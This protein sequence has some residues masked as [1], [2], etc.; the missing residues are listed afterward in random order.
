[1]I[2]KNYIEHRVTMLI[3]DRLALL[4]I[5]II[6]FSGR[7]SLSAPM[8]AC[9]FLGPPAAN[10]TRGLPVRNR[11]LYPTELRAVSTNPYRYRGWRTMCKEIQTDGED[12]VK[13]ISEEVAGQR[14]ASLAHR[15]Y[16]ILRRCWL[17]HRV[18][19]G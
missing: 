9:Q 8:F 3:A 17:A 16:H 7:G 6:G 12:G 1:M 15:S 4:A 2:A 11:V 13:S 10:R 5:G 14:I 18:G 19:L